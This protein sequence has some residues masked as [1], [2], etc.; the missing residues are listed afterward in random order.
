M[1]KLE[2]LPARQV[3]PDDDEI[4]RVA[5]TDR[6]R[7]IDLVVRRHR[8]KIFNHAA[9]ILKDYHEAVDVT[10]EVF[11]RA[12]REPRFFEA[13][14]QMKAWLFRVTSNLCFNMVR[15]RRRRTGL[16]ERNPRPTSIDADQVEVVFADE[17]QQRIAVAIAELSD[18]HRE[19]L[20]LRYYGDLSYAEIA[21]ALQI[22]LGTVMSR[23]SRA[24]NR[25][26]EVLGDSG[27]VLQ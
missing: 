10:Q 14:F 9:Y 25:L 15:D 13:G 21:D 8:D 24:R 6:R 20:E 1:G 7:A 23:L 18:D 11:I 5:A 17:R 27:V 2:L 22:R 3:L 12:M 26:A 19:I 4:R 16:L